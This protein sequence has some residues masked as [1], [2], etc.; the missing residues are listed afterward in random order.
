MNDFGFPGLSG[1]QN[2]TIGDQSFSQGNGVFAVSS[3]VEELHVGVNA[4]TH[5]TSCFIHDA[6]SL[7][8]LSIEENSFRES[9]LVLKSG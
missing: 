6:P 5:Y 8:L 1:L 3:T 7:K 4:F 9:S 2:V